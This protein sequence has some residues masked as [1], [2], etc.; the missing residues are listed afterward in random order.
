MRPQRLGHIALAVQDLEAA[1]AFYRD[2]MGMEVSSSQTLPEHGVRI[3]MVELQNT[4]LELMEPAGVDSPL[5]SFLA[6]NPRG[7]LHHMCLEVSDIGAAAQTLQEQGLQVLGD[8]TPKPGVH[9][10]PVLFLHPRDCHGTLIELE[11]CS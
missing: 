10:N 6:K 9:H 1:V 8:G 5:A 3:A 7:G 11:E 4:T 2:V